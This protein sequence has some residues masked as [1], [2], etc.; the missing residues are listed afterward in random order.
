[1]KK[2]I[3]IISTNHEFS[4]QV[5]RQAKEINSP[6]REQDESITLVLDREGGFDPF[7]ARHPTAKLEATF[8]FELYEL[9]R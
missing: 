9:K 6:I 7:C 3:P 8:T 2:P 4:Q 5:R 1:M